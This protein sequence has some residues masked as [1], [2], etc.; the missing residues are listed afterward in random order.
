MSSSS[1][2]FGNY[3]VYLLILARRVISKVR[4]VWQSQQTNIDK[5]DDKS[6]PDTDITFFPYFKME[7]IKDAF[8]KT[9]SKKKKVK[10]VHQK[11]KV[12]RVHDPKM[13]VLM[14]GVTHSVRFIFFLSF[15]LFSTH[16]PKLLNIN[17]YKDMLLRPF[18]LLSS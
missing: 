11:V 13:A 14:W 12:F 2:Y 10:A 17:R 16:F 15:F 5:R 8:T 9:K 7:S 1:R 6:R 4:R 3:R 18:F